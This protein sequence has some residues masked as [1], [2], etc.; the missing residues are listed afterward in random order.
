MNKV[1]SVSDGTSSNNM[2]D[3]CVCVESE[4]TSSKVVVIRM[5]I[6]FIC[7][8]LKKVMPIKANHGSS[9]SNESINSHVHDVKITDSTFAEESICGAS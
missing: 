3:K 5:M 2:N 8:E 6:L 1:D 9:Y 7:T 4:N